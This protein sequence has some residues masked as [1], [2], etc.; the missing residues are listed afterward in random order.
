M[1]KGLV[2]LCTPEGKMSRG[3]GARTPPSLTLSVTSPSTDTNAK[4]DFPQ[5]WH[6]RIACC[7]VTNASYASQG[8]PEEQAWVGFGRAASPKHSEVRP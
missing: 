3:R 1:S 8:G 4:C 5:H 7:C 2:S 6:K